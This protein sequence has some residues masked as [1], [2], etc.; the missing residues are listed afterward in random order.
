MVVY[1]G[2]DGGDEKRWT[3]RRVSPSGEVGEIGEFS[4]K[5]WCVMFE[6]RGKGGGSEDSAVDF[7][8]SVSVHTKDVLALSLSLSF[9]FVLSDHD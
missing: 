5:W 3:I 6:K 2:R 9:S 1:D 7:E 4:E 8:N